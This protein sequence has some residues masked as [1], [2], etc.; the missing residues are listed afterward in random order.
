MKHQTSPKKS[1]KIKHRFDTN[2][3]SNDTNEVSRI[4]K[5]AQKAYKLLSLQENLSHNEAKSL[6]D[7]GLVSINGKKL[8]IARALLSPQTKFHI[9]TPS[10]ITEIFRD[11]QILALAKPAFLTSEEIAKSYPEWVLLHRLDKETSGILL[12]V[13]DQSAFHLKAK[14]A[15]R[16]M[17]VKK[18]YVAI[19]EGI[20][21]EEQEITAP[22][23]IKKGRFA[24]VTIGKNGEGQTAITHLRPLE[25]SGKKTKLEVEI[26]TGKTHQIRVHLA[27]IKHPI[28]GDTLYGAKP[29]SRILLHA[30]SIALLGYDLMCPPPK[31]FIFKDNL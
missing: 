4:P 8:Q 24:K 3:S 20:I 25:I 12:L 14:E 5:N 21:E 6:I 26:K 1:Q 7:R 10:R 2:K 28:V 27:H 16:Q 19:V 9:Q 23:L 31:E 11:S 30:Q 29:S 15:F 22:L 18:H 17:Q 13:K